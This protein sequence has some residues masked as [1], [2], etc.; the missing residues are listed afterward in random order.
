VVLCSAAFLGEPIGLALAGGA[1]LMVVG[2]LLESNPF[3]RSAADP[4]VRRE[5]RVGVA[6]G[7]AAMLAMAVGIVIAKPVLERSA[8]LWSSVVRVASG[9]AFVAV[10]CLHPRH[11]AA[12]R[13]VFVP[14]RQWRYTIPGAVIGTYLAMVVWLAGMKYTSAGV[15]AVLNQT[16]T[17]LIPLLAVPALGEKLT[18]RKLCAVALGFCGAVVVSLWGR[19]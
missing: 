1:A 17:L 10:Q 2:I 11:H 16:N 12:V 13:Q 19:G 3:A 18:W 7:L 5:Q 14:S 4:T 9:T 15:A 8:V 6:L